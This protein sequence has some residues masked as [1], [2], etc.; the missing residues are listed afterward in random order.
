[1]ES[2]WRFGNWDSTFFELVV[3]VGVGVGVGVVGVVGV[4]EEEYG[5][6]TSGLLSIN[7]MVRFPFG[8]FGFFWRW[9]TVTVA[10]VIWQVFLLLKPNY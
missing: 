5:F 6:H 7:C 8:S 1:L 3:G 4:V 9:I 2:H 10:Q